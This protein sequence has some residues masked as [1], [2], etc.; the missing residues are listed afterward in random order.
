M[1]DAWRKFTKVISEGKELDNAY[2]VFGEFPE[3]SKLESCLQKCN[4]S[5]RVRVFL[6]NVK[7]GRLFGNN[8]VG[9]IKA[10]G[11]LLEKLADVV[12]IPVK[13]LKQYQVFTEVPLIVNAE[14]GYMKADIVLLKLSESG[15]DILDVIIIENK[16]S[17]GTAFTARQKEG[18][19]AIISQGSVEMEVKYKIENKAYTIKKGQKLRVENCKICK[20][21]DRGNPNC[22]DE[23]IFVNQIKSVKK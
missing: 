5:E 10:G 11:N 1:R 9:K 15:D 14:G 19:G 20:I 8:I 13:D 16:L 18:F 12:K 3:F 21:N 17:E 22:V 4:N 23:E 7:N 2:D 6:E